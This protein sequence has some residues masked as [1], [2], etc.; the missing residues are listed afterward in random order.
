MPPGRRPKP[1]E[2]RGCL[3]KEACAGEKAGRPVRK[4][5]SAGG[6]AGMPHEGGLCRRKGGKDRPEG[7]VSRRRKVGD[8]PQNEDGAGDRRGCFPLRMP[9][10]EERRG[11]RQ[12]E[13]RRIRK[14]KRARP[15]RKGEEPKDEDGAGR[16]RGPVWRERSAKGAGSRPEGGYGRPRGRGSWVRVGRGP[17]GVRSL[18]GGRK[19]GWFRGKRGT[20]CQGRER[21]PKPYYQ[22]N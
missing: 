10:P 3:L 14:R 20:P 6:K 17:S 8:A 5:P 11:R 22:K 13:H 12:D 1:A 9:V 16:R 19:E 18:G 2:R 21:L 4:A 15:E 7:A